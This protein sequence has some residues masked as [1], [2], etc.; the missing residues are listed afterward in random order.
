MNTSIPMEDGM[1]QR[2]VGN[3]PMVEVDG[4]YAKLECAN[5]CGSVKDRI[6]VHI[7]EESEKR[8]LLKPGMGIVEASSGNTGIAFSFFGRK[9]G[10]NVTIVMPEDMTEERKEV[11]RKLGTELVLCSKGNFA[12]A[13]EIRDR[14][15]KERGCFNPDQFSNPL[16]VECH[17]RT[18]GE[19]ILEQ[20]K[21][22]TDGPV[23]AFVAGVGTGGTLIGAGKKLRSRFP[24]VRIAAVEPEESPVM[25]GGEPGIHGISGIGDGFI[26]KI[27]TDDDGALN[28]MI[29]EV[30]CVRTD[31]AREASKYLSD[32][33]GYCVGISS[34]ANFLAAKRL[35]E[36]FETVVTLFPDGYS[37]YQSR[38]LKHCPPG[39]CPFEHEPEV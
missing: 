28:S 30:I 13:A 26:P 21:S 15:A 2:P 35:A 4:V 16:N 31:E 24:K 5:P 22:F 25:S 14:I 38:G 9:K 19:E 20:I 6:A 8:G 12:E 23:G 18:T 3:T 11:L 33:H 29:D 17:F 10:Y 36:R 37:R 1:E 39:R 32:R 27:V 7:I 34:G